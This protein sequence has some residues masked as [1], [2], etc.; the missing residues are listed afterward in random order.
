VRVVVEWQRL[1]FRNVRCWSKP[2][3]DYATRFPDAFRNIQNGDAARVLRELFDEVIEAVD[4]RPGLGPASSIAWFRSR[5]F[6][7]AL[8]ISRRRIPLLPISRRR[9]PSRRIPRSRLVSGGWHAVPV[10][11]AT[12]L[13][14][15]QLIRH[16]VGRSNIVGRSSPGIVTWMMHAAHI[17]AVVR[18]AVGLR[19]LVVLGRLLGF[20]GRL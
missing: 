3:E 1:Q 14:A 4:A 18:P 10:R 2:L 19:L 11:H 9:I 12:E 5:S 20:R 8:P 16:I 6:R 7:I 13:R 17:P 15:I